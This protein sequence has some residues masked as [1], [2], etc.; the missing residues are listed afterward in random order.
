Q[1]PDQKRIAV[2][3]DFPAW[4]QKAYPALRAPLKAKFPSFPWP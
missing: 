1:S 2:T 4:R 3:R